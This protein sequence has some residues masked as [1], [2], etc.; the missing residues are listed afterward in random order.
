M[1][2]YVFILGAGASVAAGA[3]LM[4]DFLDVAEGLHKEDK[5][6]NASEYFDLLFKGYNALRRAYAKASIDI[7]NI[8]AL[9]TAFEMANLLGRLGDLSSK[10]VERLPEAA[11]HVIEKTLSSSIMFPKEYKPKSCSQGILLQTGDQL[12]PPGGYDKLGKIISKL[13]SRGQDVN[14]VSVITFNYDLCIDYTIRCT[15]IPINYCLENDSAEKIKI[16]KLHGSLNWALCPNCGQVFP[17]DYCNNAEVS[18]EKGGDNAQI[19]IASALHRFKH[20]G[21]DAPTDLVIVPPTI[22][23]IQYQT[24]I[25]K[26]WNEAAKVLSKAEHI[27]VLGYSLP[28]TDLFFRYLFAIGTLSDS[29]IKKFWVYDIDD[30]DEFK[31]RYKNLLGPE[32]RKDGIFYTFPV[33]FINALNSI[34]TSLKLNS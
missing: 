29:R 19:H 2:K 3:P 30:S 14:N 17:I 21:A 31:N 1:S 9:F 4:K 34:S 5:C 22:G 25:K 15:G 26:V 12:I 18:F 32:L 10:E 33:N 13:I 20:C 28:E 27:F 23:K 11:S 7:D 16:L 24:Q 6:G 8:E